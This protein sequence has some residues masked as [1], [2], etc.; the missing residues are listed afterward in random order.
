MPI[1]E[2]VLGI[3]RDHVSAILGRVEL[4]V[5][6]GLKRT[7]IRTLEDALARQPSAVALLRVYASEL[8]SV[9]RDTEA[10]EVEARYAALRFDDSGFLSQM[11]DLAVARRDT[12]GRRAVAFS[13]SSEASPMGHGR[14]ASRRTRTARSVSTIAR[15]PPTSA[16]SPWRRRMSPRCAP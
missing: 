11:V 8:R 16:R 1:Y 10:S 12:A 7:A 4:Y 5:A 2:R 13:A 14:A 9:G 15:S 3:D 6:A